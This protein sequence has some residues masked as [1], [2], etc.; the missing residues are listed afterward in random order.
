MLDNLID[1]SNDGS[2]TDAPVKARQTHVSSNNIPC[3]EKKEKVLDWE[4]NLLRNWSQGHQQCHD[5]P[6]SSFDT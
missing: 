3:P 2:D 1:S 5:T 6:S 4:G